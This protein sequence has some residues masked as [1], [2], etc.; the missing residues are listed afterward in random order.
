MAIPDTHTFSLADV[1]VEIYGSRISGKGLRS[2]FTDSVD[3]KFDPTYKGAKDRL[4][5]FRNYGALNVGSLYGGGVVAYIFVSGDAGYVSGQ[6]HG[7]IA[8]IS[9]LSAGIK[10]Y[11]ATYPQ[12]TGATSSSVGSGSSNTT[13]IISVQGNSGSYAAKLCRD[14]AGG[15]YNDW[16]LPSLDELGKFYLNRIAIGGFQLT[17]SP[18]DMYVE[19][20]WSSTEWDGYSAWGLSFTNNGWS[21]NPDIMTKNNTGWRV[22]AVRYF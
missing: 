20:Y 1:V 11:N 9:D 22:R 19:F 7:L 3:A 18:P 15:G 2:C 14:Y 12:T 21:P 4:S 8:S 10:W 16:S 17:N 13:T 6:I 5:N